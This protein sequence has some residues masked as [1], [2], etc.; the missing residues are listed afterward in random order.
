MGSSHTRLAR[1]AIPLHCAWA[2]GS[3]MTINRKAQSHLG[4]KRKSISKRPQPK[5]MVLNVKTLAVKRML[6]PGLRG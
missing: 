1:I 2:I 4:D 5:E 3:W 6:I